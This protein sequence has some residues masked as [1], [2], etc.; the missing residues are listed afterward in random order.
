MK[1]S[2]LE[3]WYLFYRLLM[4]KHELPA[5]FWHK[6]KLNNPTTKQMMAI[7]AT[8]PFDKP[9]VNTVQDFLYQLDMKQHAFSGNYNYFTI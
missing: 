6:L 8:I 9:A 4:K 5:Y 1:K 3:T 2:K 7:N